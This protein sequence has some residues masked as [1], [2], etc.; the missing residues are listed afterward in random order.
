MH[1]AETLINEGVSEPGLVSVFPETPKQRIL[2]IGCDDELGSLLSH[3]GSK[4]RLSP[5]LLPTSDDP[6]AEILGDLPDIIALDPL[7]P[8]IDAVELIE[9]LSRAQSTCRLILV[10]STDRGTTDAT[11]Q[12]IRASGLALA[13]MLHKPITADALS[14]ILRNAARLQNMS[15]PA[16][17]RRWE[18]ADN[19]DFFFQPQIR[20]ADRRV[21]AY[22]ALARIHHPIYGTVSPACAP[23]LLSDQ[24]YAAGLFWACVDRSL[25]W[26]QKWNRLGFQG[27]IS[28][29]V[30]ATTLR[31]ISLPD[32]LTQRLNRHRLSP[33]RL[34][35]ELTETEH[36]G[37]G[38]GVWRTLMRL[39]L[40]GYGIAMDDFGL[41]YS[42]LSELYRLPFTE[43]KIDREFVAGLLVAEKA[44]KLV[45]AI[46]DM[47]HQL[48]IPVVAEGVEKPEQLEFLAANGCDYVQGFLVG[49]PIPGAQTTV[50]AAKRES[51]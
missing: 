43:L 32:K 15:Q 31:D 24:D 51:A 20:T 28:I 3:S 18:T 36:V 40:L 12:F 17:E 42:S 39:R 27:R 1:K 35:L 22:E 11:A 29:N 33:N 41:G 49:H 37:R 10:G 14:R 34:T 30:A 9:R 47:A 8:Q 26:L 25:F 23:D 4:F 13:G 46:I 19:A 45:P 2:L 50:P 44:K 7:V 16:A 6:I 5:T 21:I 48:D 38:T